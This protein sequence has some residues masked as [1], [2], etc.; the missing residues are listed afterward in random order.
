MVVPRQLAARVLVGVVMGVLV[1]LLPG[2]ATAFAPPV[3]EPAPAVERGPAV[4]R[5]LAISVDAL[6]PTALVRLGREGAPA[7]HRLLAEGAATLNAR[8][9]VESTETLPNHTS[10]VTGRR[11]A[12]AHHGHGVTW[13]THRPG[14]TV[15][16]AAGHPVASVFTRA[17]RAGSTALFSAKQKFSLFQRS[18]PAAIDRTVIRD[19]NDTRL[20]RAAR[21]DLVRAHRTFTFVHFGHADAVGHA[22]GFLSPAY[23]TAVR[24][25]DAAV[26]K[27]LRAIDTHPA[28]AGTAVILTADHGGA[29]G[30][31][32]HDDPRRYANY[33]IPFVVWGPGVEHG[34]LYA[35]NDAYADPGHRRVPYSGRQPIRNGDLANLALDLLGLG[36][37]PGSRY[38]VRQQLSV[39]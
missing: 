23:L 34:N 1:G 8:T 2:P 36:P 33:R 3:V 38:D 27:L 9:Q 25:V 21:A 16:G 5:V 28:L 22:K 15:Q 39:G 30:A 6:N 20:V 19:G 17:H 12:A 31:R 10:M 7:L 32:R 11:V 35:M 26:G 37:V 4:E 14:T 29:R 13:N 18:W 24:R